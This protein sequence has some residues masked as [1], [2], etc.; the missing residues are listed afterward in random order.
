MSDDPITFGGYIHPHVGS[1]G[2]LCLG[3]MSELFDAAIKDRD[4]KSLLDLTNQ[5]LVNYNNDAPYTSLY[6]YAVESKQIQP[7]G[8]VLKSEEELRNEVTSEEVTCPNCDTSFIAEITGG[9]FSGD[10]VE[11]DEFFTE[12]I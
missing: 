11:C 9:E 6:N 12:N 1:S 3:N 4:I 10:C 7:N 8:E 2:S 5:I